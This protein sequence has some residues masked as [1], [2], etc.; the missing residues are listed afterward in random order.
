MLMSGVRSGSVQGLGHDVHMLVVQADSNSVR[1]I[2]S[3]LRAVFWTK[4]PRHS[5]HKPRVR[6]AH[7]LGAGGVCANTPWNYVTSQS[8]V[9]P[10]EKRI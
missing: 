10:H 7:Q 2:Y 5:G 1:V 3:L 6:L 9:G 4:S 8:C